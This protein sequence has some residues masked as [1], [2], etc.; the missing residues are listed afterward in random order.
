MP[1]WDY[2]IDSIKALSDQ[3]RNLQVLPVDSHI[4]I[5]GA[6]IAP[7]A[8]G[9]LSNKLDQRTENAM[10][11]SHFEDRMRPWIFSIGADA[12]YNATD[13]TIPDSNA[14]FQDGQILFIPEKFSLWEYI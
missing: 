13:L 7:I 6:E 2:G 14:N 3:I 12:A 1:V 4:S 10:Q 5:L 8:S 11:S 9:L